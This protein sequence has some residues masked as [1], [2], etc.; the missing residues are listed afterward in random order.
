MGAS[1]AENREELSVDKLR[2]DLKAL[3]NVEVQR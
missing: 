1:L 2:D 3:A